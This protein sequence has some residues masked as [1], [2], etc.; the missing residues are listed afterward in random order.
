MGAV[1]RLALLHIERHPREAGRLLQTLPADRVAE[2]LGG[3]PAEAGAA[4]AASIDP[5]TAADLLRRVQ[6]G[7][8]AGIVE[9]MEDRAATRVLFRLDPAFRAELMK[10]LPPAHARR[11]ERMFDYGPGT[12]GALMSP[13][14]TEVPQD[15][16]AASALRQVRRFTKSLRYYVYATDPGGRA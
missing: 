1:S 9:R 6:A 14:V 4:V 7:G 5:E 16:D 2:A 3:W 8:A 13:A 11:L 15:L 12:A 10:G